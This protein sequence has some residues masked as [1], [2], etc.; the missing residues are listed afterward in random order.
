MITIA[1]RLIPAAL[2]AARTISTGGCMYA[3]MAKPKAE[4]IV[5]MVCLR[6]IMSNE[7]L[8]ARIGGSLHFV[9]PQRRPRAGVLF[10]H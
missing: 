1:R 7:R 4:K 5:T 6:W 3:A 8:G 9:N 10:S 2:I